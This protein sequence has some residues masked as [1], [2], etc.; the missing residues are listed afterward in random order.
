MREAE[1]RARGE[2]KSH[3]RSRALR[4]QM[5]NR[6]PVLQPTRKTESRTTAQ[7]RPQ[8]NTEMAKSSRDSPFLSCLP[9]GLVLES[10]DLV[11]GRV[12]AWPQL[13]CEE[14]EL[15]QSAPRLLLLELRRA[16]RRA[17]SCL[18]A[19]RQRQGEWAEQR[20]ERRLV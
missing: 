19:C 2:T 16:R 7:K 17:H 1:A 12:P 5:P 20:A 4:A 8:L 3:V 6:T 18:G 15:G 9:E 14:L 10:Q 11:P 13:P